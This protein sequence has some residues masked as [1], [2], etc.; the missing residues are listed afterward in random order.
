MAQS[1]F[2]RETLLD[3]SVNIIPL[4]IILFFLVLFTIIR[5]FPPDT[6]SFV[7]MVGLHVVPFVSLAILTYYSGK[8]IAESEAEMESRTD[9]VTHGD[10]GGERSGAQAGESGETTSA[11]EGH[12]SSNQE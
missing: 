8:A 9:V 12:S 6:V 1:V 11:V 4:F 2:D 5:P 7:I 3:L 10:S